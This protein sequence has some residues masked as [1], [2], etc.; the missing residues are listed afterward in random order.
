MDWLA[1]RVGRRIFA[2]HPYARF[3]LWLAFL[4][5]NLAMIG[6]AVGIHRYGLLVQQ[7]GFMATSLL[8]IY[9]AWRCAPKRHNERQQT[10]SAAMP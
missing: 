8:G 6:F 3:T 4:A 1:F 5:A 9:R 10:H 2:G 7:V